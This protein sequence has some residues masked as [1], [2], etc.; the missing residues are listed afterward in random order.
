M[1]PYKIYDV[2]RL[3]SQGPT[4]RQI[5]KITDVSRATVGRYRKDP[6][7]GMNTQ[8]HRRPKV[9]KLDSGDRAQLKESLSKAKGNCAIARMLG[10]ALK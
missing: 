8:S 4:N 6:N 3:I 9:Y 2:A 7:H 10:A 5:E 1:N